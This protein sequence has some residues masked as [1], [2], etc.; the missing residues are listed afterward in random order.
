[1]E[2]YYTGWEPPSIIVDGNRTLKSEI[3]C[4]D[5]EDQ[6]SFENS[7]ALNAIYNGVDQNVFKLINT[8]TSTKKSLE[9][10]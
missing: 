6:A 5:A 8:C 1:M 4:T 9:N 3:D 10:S 7:H 2:S